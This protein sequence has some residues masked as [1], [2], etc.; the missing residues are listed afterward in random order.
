MERQREGRRPR[1]GGP[2]RWRL[3][4]RR[5]EPRREVGLD[6]AFRREWEGTREGGVAAA[7]QAGGQREPGRE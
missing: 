2:A 5:R 1:R 6:A 7:G 3:H 4:E